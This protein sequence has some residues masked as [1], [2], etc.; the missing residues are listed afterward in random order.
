MLISFY[1]F[2][3]RCKGRAFH[4]TPSRSQHYRR[5]LLI[6]YFAARRR[7]FIER[8]ASLLRAAAYYRL[9]SASMLRCLIRLIDMFYHADISRLYDAGLLLPTPDA[10]LLISIAIWHDTIYTVLERG[11]KKMGFHW[12][13]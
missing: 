10:I 13:C 2:K 12:P 1:S 11:R 6:F 4:N 5:L 3:M 8:Y 7:L 9:I